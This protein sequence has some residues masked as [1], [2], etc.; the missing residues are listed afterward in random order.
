MLASFLNVVARRDRVFALM[1]GAEFQEFKSIVVVLKTLGHPHKIVYC[2]LMGVGVKHLDNIQLV[3]V[4]EQEH[5]H[6]HVAGIEIVNEKLDDVLSVR[7]TKVVPA[8]LYDI[9]FG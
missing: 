1:D 7:I 3:G 4:A 9:R 6:M 2:E 8:N 5:Y